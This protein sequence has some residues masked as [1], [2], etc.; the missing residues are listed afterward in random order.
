MSGLLVKSTLIMKENLDVMK[1]RGLQL[2]V[3]LGGAALTRRFV[4]EDLAPLYN[5]ELRYAKDAFDGLRLMNDIA[6]GT[7]STQL[8]AAESAT[9]AD[10][11]ESLS[12]M[13]A[14]IA[15]AEMEN[16]GKEI[17]HDAFAGQSV[18]TRGV[19]VPQAPFLGSR[20]VNNV[21]IDKV[22]QFVNEV[23][24]IRGQWQFRRGTKDEESYKKELDEIVYPRLKELKLKLKR[25][26]VLRPAVAY[27]YFPC[28]SDGNDL[29]VYRPKGIDEGALIR[30]WP[31]AHYSLSDLEEWQRFKFPRQ[32]S[33]R[34]LCIADYFR[35]VDE[36][37]P[38]VCAFHIVTMGSYASDYAA[39]LFKENRYQEYLY[40]HGLSVECAEALAEYWHKSIRSELGIGDKDARYIK[41]LFSQGYQGSRYSFGYPACPNLEDQR[42]LFSL[43][44]PERIG[45]S[46]TEEFQLVP[47]QSTSA[48]IVHHPEA[49]YFNVK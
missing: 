10:E 49:K 13:E 35:N 7:I 30:E 17:N 4:N 40:V 46:L 3:I 16:D 24:L 9:Q 31:S 36:G 11:A 26:K 34:Y 45:I 23:A 15:A 5:G 44:R 6:E 2:P 43:L 22:Y 47:E 48:I 19:L 37:D 21:S 32:T 41:R 27:G 1:Q 20:T 18:V 14:K 25:E 8:A 42:Q 28:H 39:E 38:D 33:D 29:V 12:G